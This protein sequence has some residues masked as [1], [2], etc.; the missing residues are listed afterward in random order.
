MA[1]KL[2]FDKYLVLG[3]P[4]SEEE[5][6]NYSIGLKNFFLRAHSEKS[7]NKEFEKLN[8]RKDQG[9]LLISTN[10]RLENLLARVVDHRR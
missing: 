3:L 1:E 8:S 7:N 2:A 6:D 4:F 5:K 10:Q 9:S